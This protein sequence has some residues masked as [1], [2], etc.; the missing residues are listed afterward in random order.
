MDLGNNLEL[1]SE[2][3]VS[4]AAAAAAAKVLQFTALADFP[5]SCEARTRSNEWGIALGNVRLR[6]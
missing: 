3:A 6:G 1:E 4:A 2:P 5:Q